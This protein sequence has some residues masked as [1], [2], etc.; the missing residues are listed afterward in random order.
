MINVLSPRILVALL[1]SICLLASGKAALASDDTLLLPSIGTTEHD[2]QRRFA[3]VQVYQPQTDG[4]H[5]YVMHASDGSEATVHLE[6]AKNRHGQLIVKTVKINTGRTGSPLSSAWLRAFHTTYSFDRASIS[7]STLSASDRNDGTPQD[8][9]EIS[10][11]RMASLESLNDGWYADKSDAN[12][13]VW[14]RGSCPNEPATLI[15]EY[16][17]HPG[18]DIEIYS[19]FLGGCYPAE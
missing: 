12:H 17:D 6:Y 8:N 3:N 1:A 2:V 19:E 15:M 4:I 13:I 10:F 16:S 18:A 5:I 11:H 14:K 9:E 7:L